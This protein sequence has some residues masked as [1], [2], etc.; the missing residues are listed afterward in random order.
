MRKKFYYNGVYL[1]K[2]RK[3]LFS[4]YCTKISGVVLDS[5]YPSIYKV[6]QKI[7]VPMSAGHFKEIDKNI[8]EGLKNFGFI[9]ND[10]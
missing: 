9:E 10:K 8:V 2:G 5:C 1:I 4:T 6:G 3:K 7:T